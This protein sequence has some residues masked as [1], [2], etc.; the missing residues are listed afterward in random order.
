MFERLKKIL[1][2]GEGNQRVDA[3]KHIG[4]RN[5]LTLANF[6]DRDCNWLSVSLMPSLKQSLQI[7]EL[8]VA[9]KE[10]NHR[11]VNWSSFNCLVPER[12][13]H[14]TNFLA[15]ILNNNT[16]QHNINLNGHHIEQRNPALIR[17]YQWIVFTSL[18]IRNP[19]K[20]CDQNRTAVVA[21]RQAITYLKSNL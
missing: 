2:G 1:W 18:T 10:K 12:T 11:Y 7:C 17:Y 14:M 16:T 3:I 21:L 9:E 8:T 13:E 6:F 4:P 5:V 20:K 19:K 15:W